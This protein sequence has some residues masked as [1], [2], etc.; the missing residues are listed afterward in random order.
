MDEKCSICANYYEVCPSCKV[1][2][3]KLKGCVEDK[4]PGWHDNGG[5]VSAPDEEKQ[6]TGSWLKSKN[7][8]K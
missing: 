6:S 5:Y 8:K 1:H 7:E 4:K 3:V 2:G